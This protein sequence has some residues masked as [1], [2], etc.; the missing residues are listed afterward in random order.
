MLNSYHCKNLQNMLI[1]YFLSMC[2]LYPYLVLFHA[3]RCFVFQMLSLYLSVIYLALS[4][5]VVA[6]SH[7]PC[8][9]VTI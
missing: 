3:F 4:K 1:H 7:M 5:F 2:E 6:T 9:C 8:P